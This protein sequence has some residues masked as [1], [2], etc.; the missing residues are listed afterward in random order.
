MGCNLKTI[1]NMVKVLFC[2]LFGIQ[3]CTQWCLLQQY[4]KILL[5][6]PFLGGS[7]FSSYE[8]E[9]RKMMSNF[10]IL[11]QKYLQ[12]FIFYVTNS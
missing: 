7:D 2:F 3:F 12:K 1:E 9:L 5:R 6:R 4:L 8:T 11:T 10:E